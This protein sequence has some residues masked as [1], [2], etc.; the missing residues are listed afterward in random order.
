MLQQTRHMNSGKWQLM[1][2]SLSL[3]LVALVLFGPLA[4]LALAGQNKTSVCH[5]TG[6]YDFGNGPVPIGHVIT[7][8]DPAL[9]SHIDHGDAVDYTLQTLPDGGTVC[10]PNFDNDGDGVPDSADACDNPGALAV[11]DA[12][13]IAYTITDDGCI[14]VSGTLPYGADLSGIDLSGA[15]LSG[16]NLN[17]VSISGADLSDADLSGTTGAF[18][19]GS[20]PVFADGANLSGAN[21][22]LAYLRGS[23]F[24]NVNLSDVDFTD[25]F[26]IDVDFTGADFSGAIFDNTRCPD[27]TPSD[28]A[29]G[30]CIN[31]L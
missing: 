12:E 28:F 11:L 19:G 26:L 6:T 4:G 17:G 30:T 22:T 9:P 3:L 2:T 1:V 25:A 23:S 24:V 14:V 5:V 18:V 31:N 15:I 16:V 10:T 7:I 13:G 21:L 29:G 8:A 27:G 20:S